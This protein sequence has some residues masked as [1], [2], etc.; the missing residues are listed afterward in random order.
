MSVGGYLNGC[1]KTQA[2]VGGTIPKTRVLHLHR[3][4]EMELSISK[5]M[6]GTHTLLLLTEG[7]I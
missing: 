4:R 2:S 7:V 5:Q 1:G 6:A 3:T